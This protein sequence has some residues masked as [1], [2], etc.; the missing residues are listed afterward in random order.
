M[1]RRRPPHLLEREE[2]EE[3]E[4]EGRWRRWEREE[5]V[6]AS[7]TSERERADRRR[8]KGKMRQKHLEAQSISLSPSLRHH[9]FDSYFPSRLQL[10]GTLTL[11]DY[12]FPSRPL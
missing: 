6:K 1:R 10:G 11:S 4:E 3:G 2:E 12:F 7:R 8:A 5:E 9:F